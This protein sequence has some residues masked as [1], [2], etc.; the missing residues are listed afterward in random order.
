MTNAIVFDT[1]VRTVCTVPS[2]AQDFQLIRHN[3]V[4]QNGEDEWPWINVLIC[5][6][7]AL[8][9][10]TLFVFMFF[11]IANYNLMFSQR[12]QLDVVGSLFY[13]RFGKERKRKRKSF[14]SWTAAELKRNG[15][16]SV[17]V[18]GGDGSWM[19]LCGNIYSLVIYTLPV[20]V[21]FSFFFSFLFHFPIRLLH[22]F[23]WIYL[24]VYSVCV[25][26]CV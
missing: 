18:W 11:N 5:G 7:D 23:I 3:L 4:A 26:V 1:P 17:C 2:S 25:C 12:L 6:D 21:T 10:R 19:D 8:R 20:C 9:E 15:G 16:W 14:D 22:L 13:C 24:S